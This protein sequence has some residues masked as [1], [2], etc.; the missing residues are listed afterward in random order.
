MSL[1][2]QKEVGPISAAR[3]VMLL[4][5]H[6]KRPGGSITALSPLPPKSL[7]LCVSESE[8]V[9]ESNPERDSGD[10]RRRHELEAAASGSGYQVDFE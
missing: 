4:P 2:N 9:G 6:F 3:L 10:T 5:F 8:Y 1:S 7:P